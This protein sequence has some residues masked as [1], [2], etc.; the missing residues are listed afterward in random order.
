MDRVDYCQVCQMYNI[1]GKHTVKYDGVEYH[2]KALQL[3]Y[4]K[5]GTPKYTA[6]LQ[7]VTARH[8]IVHC[9]LEAVEP[10]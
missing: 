5:D 7:S 1:M 10:V 6:V 3:T 4:N 2:P 8:S 9:R